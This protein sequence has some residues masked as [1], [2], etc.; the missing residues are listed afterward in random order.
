MILRVG[1]DDAL[2]KEETSNSDKF[3][4]T[5]SHSKMYLLSVI[6][7]TKI[8]SNGTLR[9]L[10]CKNLL[11]KIFLL[12]PSPSASSKFGLSILNFFKHAL[13]KLAHLSTP[14]MF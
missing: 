6:K 5:T 4:A 9:N 8:N 2:K 11:K 14:K 1:S 7:I 12:L 10:I 3:G 13:H